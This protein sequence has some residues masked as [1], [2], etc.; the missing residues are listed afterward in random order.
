METNKKW[1][2]HE[3]QGVMENDT[4][5]ILWNFVIQ[6]DRQLI[7]RKPDIVVVD[8]SQKEARIIDVAIPGN[9]RVI[10][11][12]Q[13]KVDKYQP[14]KD[15]ITRLW[16][17]KKVEIIPIIVGALGTVLKNFGKY[18]ERSGIELNIENA[19]KQPEF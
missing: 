5:K 18:V 2:D 12:E 16:N 14:L 10:E 17:M 19:Q 8:K 1:Y 13:E 7:G 15:E 6:C 4:V 11:K 9:A 3:P